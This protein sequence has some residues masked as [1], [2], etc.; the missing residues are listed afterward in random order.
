M[1][2]KKL[3]KKGLPIKQLEIAQIDYKKHHWNES[4]QAIELLRRRG[5]STA[6]YS[7]DNY[8]QI[9]S[10]IPTSSRTIITA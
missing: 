10:T 1:T 4:L 2:Q 3:I 6:N 5:S 9:W 8:A 7:M